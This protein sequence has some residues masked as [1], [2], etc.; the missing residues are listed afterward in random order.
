MIYLVIKQLLSSTQVNN[1]DSAVDCYLLIVISSHINLLKINISFEIR[2]VLLTLSYFRIYVRLE[3]EGCFCL[4]TFAHASI[5]N[6]K[7]KHEK[8]LHKQYQVK[9]LNP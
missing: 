5:H 8:G 2:H 1:V 4:P 9:I 7:C 6:E 3:V